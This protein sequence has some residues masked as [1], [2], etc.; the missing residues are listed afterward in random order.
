[1]IQLAATILGVLALVWAGAGS[2]LGGVYQDFDLPGSNYVLYHDYGAAAAQVLSGGPSD[3]FLRLNYAT[4]GSNQNFIVFTDHSDGLAQRIIADF[5]FRMYGGSRADGIG[6]ALLNTAYYGRTSTTGDMWGPAEE[7]N[8]VGSLGIGFDIF[9]NSE[10]GNN[11]LSLHYNNSLLANFH[12]TA[13]QLWTSTETNFNHA[14]IEVDLA[15]KTV[16]V[17]LTPPPA[18]RPSRC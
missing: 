2:A 13:M 5:D 9:N 7:P 8:R 12:L 18:G 15:A 10:G 16:S 1:M 11:H 17:A 3:N 4:V 14:H 6:F